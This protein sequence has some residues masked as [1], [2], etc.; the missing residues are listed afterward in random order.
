[1]YPVQS[2]SRQ[3]NNYYQPA[4]LMLVRTRLLQ[5]RQVCLHANGSSMLPLIRHG[6]ALWVEYIEPADLRRGDL[7]LVQRDNRLITHRLVACHQGMLQ[8]RGDNCLALDPPVL[9]AEIL[10]RVSTIE[11]G[12]KRIALHSRLWRITSRLLVWSGWLKAHPVSSNPP[13]STQCRLY[14]YVL[15]GLHTAVVRV[16][17]GCTLILT[18]HTIEPKEHYAAIVR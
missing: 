18:R 4:L 2:L 7:V 17:T 12:R 16:L 3:N 6:D 15:R 5:Q 8:T 14:R 13:D 11:R 9:A 10:G 1:M